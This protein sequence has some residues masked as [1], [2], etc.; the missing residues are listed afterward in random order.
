VVNVKKTLAV[1]LFVSIIGS[2]LASWNSVNDGLPS[3]VF[4]STQSDYATTSLRFSLDGY[5]TRV[6]E[7]AGTR[8]TEFTYENEGHLL[9][10]G[11]PAFPQFSRMI[12]IP[13]EG[14]VRYTVRSSKQ[15][16]L[17]NTI[18][19][20]AQ[21]LQVESDP[22]AIP[23]EID[24]AWYRQGTPYPQQMIEISDP[25]IMRDYR[26]VF[27]TINPFQY[28]PA[29]QAVTVIHDVELDVT[30]SGSGGI[31]A[32]R[33]NERHSVSFDQFAK[34]ATLNYAETRDD[35]FEPPCY[36]I[37]YPSNDDV[38]TTLEVLA[39]WKHQKGHEV[40]LASTMETGT[41]DVAIK[42]YIQTAY[43][44]WD[45]APDFV[46]L[47]GDADGSFS[48]P[49]HSIDQGYGDHYYTLLDG[50]DL[51]PE[52]FIGRLSFDTVF[53]L[54]T[55]VSKI[56]NYEKQPY[57]LSTE[58]YEQACLV[59]DT[60]SSGQSTIDT[61]V[62]IGNLI[63]NHNPNFELDEIYTG[64]FESQMAASMNDGV[65]F[66][67]Y[68]GYIGM[69]GWDNT[70]INA[71]TNGF[72]LPV[73]VFITCATGNFDGYSEARNE[74]FL[75]AGTPST[76]KGAIAA[77]GTVTSSTHTCFNNAVSS[78]TY[79][80]IFQ[81]GI[82]N[83]GGALAFGKINMHTTYP[84]DPNNHTT[85][86][87][88]WNNLMGD[89]GMEV[90][91][92]VPEDMTVTYES[93][94]A[95][96]TNYLPVTVTN[97][98]GAPLEGAWVTA[99]MGDDDIFATGLTNAQGEVVLPIATTGSGSVSLTVTKHNFKPHLGGF[100]LGQVAQYVDVYDVT[101]DDDMN[102]GSTGNANGMVNPGETIQMP[103]DLKNFGTSAVSGVTAT[104]SANTNGVTISDNSEDFGSIA[105][106][107]TASSQDAFVFTVN[108]NVLGG[109]VIDF[110]LLIE[111]GA[112]NDWTTK[113]YLDT[114]GA[115]LMA[116]DF[117]AVGGNGIIDPGDT[118]P[119]TV[120]LANVGTVGISNVTATLIS[121]DTDIVIEDGDGFYTSI[122]PGGSATNTVNTFEITANAQIIPGSQ[123][124]LDMQL[125]SPEGYADIIPVLIEVGEVSITD[126]LGPDAY[127]YYC[128][129]D[130][131]VDYLKAPT[132]E[133]V[134]ID[135]SLGGA[136]TNLN[137][138]DG[139]DGG[140]ITT[141]DIPFSLQFYGETYDEMTICTNGWM[142]P[143]E[144]DNRSYM[145]WIIPG[146][147]G[148]SPIIAPFWDDLK[149]SGG[150]VVTY[151]D[152]ALNRWIV[153][154]SQMHNDYD[155][156]EETFQVII[157]DTAYYPTS[158]GDNEILFQY[159]VFNNVDQGDYFNYHVSHGCYATVGLEDHTAS[160]GI[161]Y[162]FN[163]EYPTAAKPITNET[164]ILFTGPPVPMQEPYLVLGDFVYLETQGNGNGIPEYAEELSMYIALNN[165]G[166]DM[167][168][169]V[170]A[171]VTLNDP[172]V[173]L[174][175]STCSFNNVAGGAQ[176]LSIDPLQLTIAADCPDGHMVGM[177]ID[178]TS[179]QG[180]WVYNHGF[181]L[182]APNMQ[183]Y[184]VLVDDG[185]NNVLD[186]GETADL[187]ISLQNNGSAAV[188]GSE[189][190][191]STTSSYL[192][193]N[194]ATAALGAVPGGAIST[195]IINVTASANAPVGTSVPLN[196]DLTCDYGYTA[197]G[198]ASVTISQIPVALEEHFDTFPPT[199]WTTTGG[200]NWQG[201]S[202]NNAGGTSPEAHFYWSPSTNGIQRL[203]S[204]VMNTLGSAELTLEFK[205]MLD[206]YSGGYEIRVETTSNG[207]TWNTVW[208]ENPNAN[209]GPE[210]I[211]E[212]VTT[213]DV[214]SPTFQI[215]W[216]F[217]G[218]SFNLDHWY[219][220]DVL[221]GGGSG[222]TMGYM[223]GTVTLNGGAGNVEDVVISAGN[224]T[225]SPDANGN[226]TLVAMPGTYDV[227][228][229]L[230]GYEPASY[231]NITVQQQQTTTLNIE[232]NEMAALNPPQNLALD[233][234]ANDVALTWDAPAAQAAAENFTASRSIKQ[235]RSSREDTDNTRALTGYRV[236]R[237]SM[238]VGQV[239]DP[240][241]LTYDDTD[242]AAGDYSYHVV[243]V[244]DEG[245][246]TPSN[247]ETVT[248]I[249][250]AP[251]NFNAVS[252][253]P[254]SSD[255]ICSWDAPAAT[256]NL[257]GYIVYRDAVEV[258]NTTQLT[259]TDTGVPTGTY[260][261][262][263]TAQYSA[264]YESAASNS[265]TL[266]HTDAP[267][268]LVPVA[269]ALN[270]NYPNPF[271]PTTEIHFSLRES[272]HVRIDVF[273][274][275]GEKV[276]T[277]VN[278][279]LDAAFHTVVWNGKDDENRTTGSG[280]YFYKMRAGKFT[281][282]KKMILMK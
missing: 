33:S 132:Y 156:S 111:D 147:G 29:T 67:N 195:A 117:A 146:P 121:T 179:D 56:L 223:A 60:S 86:F 106:G 162:S 70:S 260:T 131:D 276:R 226:Y 175:G 26:V 133:W 199:D 61:N 250:A 17:Q 126:P 125:S 163:N 119:I 82:Y 262:H 2:L 252:Q 218:N 127:G 83:M 254:A 261:Y 212:T 275:K 215:A 224:F 154:W 46:M 32:L 31:N 238:M 78:G 246:S 123:F 148:P 153:E 188:Y 240:A 62:Q 77:I 150:S 236:Y 122:L 55:I 208:S 79:Q 183:L 59:G 220:D 227:T 6:I 24:D 274:I 210:T 50:T 228:A 222:G 207:S 231:T 116:T 205:H 243:A 176:A 193:I 161:Q 259:F 25:M 85:H 7:E 97:A 12:I 53:E 164:A 47:A 206:D 160:R 185:A 251:Q 166:E 84:G 256:R 135:P 130:E 182:H 93:A 202:S 189:F 157:Y 81:E 194:N 155:G 144:T 4:E 51:L 137:L 265:V 138:N 142:T 257:T 255:V 34:S 109:T 263:V 28:D 168:T 10:I 57:M 75:R 270:G 145:N 124:T 203:V 230:M 35:D 213:P 171:S 45:N 278:G 41:S 234:N 235:A 91:T 80:A 94:V 30:V 92:G 101:I 23:F 204:P 63:Q 1:V 69:S 192:T 22:R 15:A 14:S 253:G 36:L 248:I 113:I 280:I 38:L 96:G 159:K 3:L 198:N 120:T 225:A 174:S 110:D 40:H 178:I 266:D 136:G 167:A 268:P 73:A 242:L 196:W 112:G 95:Q 72:K 103:I 128:Y 272:G 27:V 8:F 11:K 102:G 201:G 237:N 98:F 129:D 197:N 267:A 20:P 186:P 107:A 49:T 244:Y 134:E 42:N 88:Y 66:F 19:Y 221:I 249:M 219:V 108:G 191:I 282:T 273:N 141:V 241:I 89:P 76:P 65:S 21:Q 211:T 64:P 232:L 271:N 190:S 181:E 13:N 269:T 87:M 5:E 158:N 54:Q 152:V 239:D 71:M 16:V 258:G 44:T 245:L 233:A 165:L 216:T 9:E 151:H 281:S 43:D 173:S 105:A 90:W 100:S 247:T 37:I 184:S 277:L 172:Y 99:L 187:L 264:Q 39:D 139:G 279:T 104:L 115:Y 58:W 229:T 48:I 169:G 140:A 74:V 170:S 180:S 209:I 118:T 177:Q 143:G 18:P 149:N 217:D 52:L 214:G 114:Y 200:G 68:R